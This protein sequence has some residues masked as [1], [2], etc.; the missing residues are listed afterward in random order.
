MANI[1]LHTDAESIRI[2]ADNGSLI[3]DLLFNAKHAITMPCAGS[4]RCGKC[5][6]KAVGALSAPSEEEKTAIGKIA[7]SQNIR[8]AC[9]TR[10]EGDAEI[11]LL[12]AP[13]LEGISTWGKMPKISHKHMFKHCGVAI[14]IGTTTLAARLYRENFPPV[15]ATAANPQ[16]CFGT[17]VIS[18]I[19][20]ALGGFDGEL[21]Q[22]IR[23]ALSHMIKTLAAD[24]NISLDN[25]DALVITGNTAML[26]LFTQHNTDC[27]AHSPFQADELFG[28]IIDAKLLGLPCKNAA[29]YLPRCISAFVGADITTAL[30]ASEICERE[31][32]ALL[33]DIGTNGEMAL[34]HN[35]SLLCCSTAAGPAFEGAGLS[36]GVQGV[37]GAI[38]CVAYTHTLPLKVHTIEDAPPCGIC[39][40][41]I[42]SALAAMKSADIIDETG[43][44]Q[45]N[46]EKYD[47]TE[48]ISITQRDIRMV[49]LAKS[50]VCAGIYTMLDICGISYTEITRLAIAGGFGSYLD[51]DA[52]AEI[53]IFPF[54]LREKAE[55]LGNAA[56]T[57][58]AMIL[59]DSDLAQRAENMANAAK[60]ADLGTSKAFMEH[61]MDCMSF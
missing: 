4:G 24:A 2:S 15:T 22:T 43:Y 35:G 23:S 21:A 3:S 17:D 53:G 44:L 57:G 40:S 34:W 50:A 58:A 7:I 48:K 55:V 42:V 29:V 36:M 61:Y 51:L 9:C 59:L 20:K 45:S 31:D 33:A 5:R 8:L 26:Y 13:K 12:S 1:V 37:A 14:D 56:L 28:K 11:T 39:G 27:L 38:D 49:Q 6:V 52:A 10:V 32:T 16:S 41:G 30:L 18:R 47:L 19:E 54:E 46:E 60:T 25:I